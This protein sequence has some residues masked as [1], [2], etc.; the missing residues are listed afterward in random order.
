MLYGEDSYFRYKGW[1]IDMILYSAYVKVGGG[2]ERRFL[3]FR[4]MP[5]QVKESL[6][7]DFGILIIKLGQLGFIYLPFRVSKYLVWFSVVPPLAF[8]SIVH[9]PVAE[10]GDDL[11]GSYEL[12]SPLIIKLN[13]H[14]LL[15]NDV[16]SLHFSINFIRKSIQYK[17]WYS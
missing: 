14:L 15:L 4:T 13:I 7:D 1:Q 2:K 8:S 6:K 12:R 10:P 16:A 9:S 5:V 3:V 17:K 11:F